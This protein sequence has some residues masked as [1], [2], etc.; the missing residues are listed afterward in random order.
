MN[1]EA[2]PSLVALAVL[3]GVFAALLRQRPTE[4]LNLWLAGWIFVLAHFVAQFLDAGQSLWEHWMAAFS[5]NFLQLAAMTFLLSVYPLAQDRQ[6]QLRIATQ[7]GVPTLLYA[8]AAVWSV[9]AAGVYYVLITLA[10][11]GTVLL[12]W[13]SYRNL[14]AHVVRLLI[15]C[16]TIAL[17]MVGCVSCNRQ[18]VAITMLL[19]IPNLVT[20]FLYWRHSRPFTTGV[21]TTGVGFLTWGAIFPCAALLERF[22]PT[23]HVESEVWNIP[24]YFV[25]IGMIVI[26]LEENVQESSYL[27]D[28]DELTGLPNRRLLEDRL[29]Q[30]LSRAARKRSK[31]AILVLDLDH[32]KEVNDTYGH[33]AGDLALQQVAIRL[34]NRIRVSDT[35]ARSGGDEFTV[36]SDVVD[37]AGAQVLVSNL[38]AAFAV[39][40]ELEGKLI[41]SGLSIGLA[42]YPD[43][44]SDS[45]KLC[46]VADE[47]MY[48]AKRAK[49][50]QSTVVDFVHSETFEPTSR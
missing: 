3:V 21:L 16:T 35:V 41:P 47:A 44:G 23:V 33:R 7:V 2:L 46:A 13:S 15:G 24:K 1:F 49:R 28:H 18:D 38:Q 50:G 40:F 32:F 10:F 31:I 45:D 6:R 8:D 5:L 30:A 4:R 42:L 14:T 48:A 25:A 22:A 17:A 20:A 43:D 9:T 37:A 34:T 27:A 11:G 19:S 36:I 39:P 12:V 26:L 29:K